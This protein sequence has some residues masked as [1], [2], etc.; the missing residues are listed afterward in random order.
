MEYFPILK[1][2]R[3]LFHADFH[4]SPLFITQI[5]SII[6]LYYTSSPLAELCAREGPALQMMRPTQIYSPLTRVMMSFQKRICTICFNNALVLFKTPRR[7][8]LGVIHEIQHRT[9]QSAAVG[10]TDAASI[11]FQALIRFCLD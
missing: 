2:S 9:A 5:Y 6:N 1:I 8:K 11:H 3:N 10:N 7:T 4:I